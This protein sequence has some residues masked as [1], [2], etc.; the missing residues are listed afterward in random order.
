[1][2]IVYMEQYEGAVNEGHK[3]NSIWD[4][5]TKKPGKMNSL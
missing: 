4:T 2:A 5:F 1:M 3:G